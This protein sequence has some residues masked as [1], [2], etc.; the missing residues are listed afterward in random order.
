MI[1]SPGRSSRSRS[2]RWSAASDPVARPS[3]SAVGA[4]M[5]ISPGAAGTSCGAGG[6]GWGTSRGGGGPGGGWGGGGGDDRPAARS[7]PS[8]VRTRTPLSA[9]GSPAARLVEQ[10]L[11]GDDPP[12]DRA[13]E[14][15]VEHRTGQ[16]GA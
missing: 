3:S 1:S 8:G 2:D 16:G 7:V 15:G 4:A 14:G 13:D 6:A 12:A 5:W 11:E 9:R 10:R